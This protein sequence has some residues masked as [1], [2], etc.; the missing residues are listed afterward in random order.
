MTAMLMRFTDGELQLEVTRY[1]KI[2][3]CRTPQPEFLS[4]RTPTTPAVAAPL[5]CPQ[6]NLNTEQN[7]GMI[8]IKNKKETWYIVNSESG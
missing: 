6:K 3:G 7:V 1:S 5:V 2:L 4:A 8:I